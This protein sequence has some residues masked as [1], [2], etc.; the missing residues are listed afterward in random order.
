[1]RVAPG[2]A[3]PH[4]NLA[5]LLLRQRQPA[6]ALQHGLC[7]VLL[8]P[9][10]AEGYNNLGTI[11][12]DQGQDD[13]A[14]TDFARA[15]RLA[16]ESPD[17][18]INDSGL[19]LDRGDVD[20]G[21]A[22]SRV[23]VLLAPGQADAYNNLA[24]GALLACALDVAERAF[25]CALTLAPEDA[26]THVNFAAVL[27]KQ[28]RLAEGWREYEW[29]RR[30]PAA[31]A[32]R[33]PDDPPDW[34]GGDPRGLTLL[35]DAEQGLG[36]ALQFCRFAPWLAAQGARV[37]LRTHAPLQRLMQSLDGVAGVLGPDDPTPAADYHL[38]LMSV[39]SRFALALPDLPARL[40]YLA[41]PAELVAAWRRRLAPLP[42]IRIG[43]VWSGD[44]RPQQ[45]A[46]HRLDRRRSM[47][48]AQLA[49][50]GAVP[51][52]TLVSLQKGAAALQT[53]PAGLALV[54]WTAELE[55]FVDTAALVSGLDLVISVDTSVAH[56]AAALNVPVWIL[57]RFDGCWRWLQG[58]QD[59]PW[60]PA[61]RLFHQPAPG[62]WDSVVTAVIAALQPLS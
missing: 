12:L 47:T 26:Q 32:R 42:G 53:P 48:L 59:S 36:D 44:P 27:L 3:S 46:A 28:G 31:L 21:R 7:A 50:L 20:S 24:N 33:R 22:H 15:R 39:P 6:A 4:G 57:S 52:V 35:L 8:Q 62:D 61:V 60:Y 40:P 16:P 43:L 30:T 29:R 17:A 49:R 34:P 19:R 25:R 14:A 38:P 45:R 13:P 5:A 55:D 2:Q 9:A 51:G 56:L 58:R 10:A 37:W 1:M 41:A 11:R 23:A 54:D 18:W